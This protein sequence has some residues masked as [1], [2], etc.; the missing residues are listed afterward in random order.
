ML[1]VA[2]GDEFKPSHL[3]VWSLKYFKLM[4]TIQNADLKEINKIKEIYN[5]A[6]VE[7][8]NSRFFASAG[9]SNV[10]KIW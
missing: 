7:G 3:S 8:L 9:K 6:K 2:E 1:I 5:F 10:V 4:Q